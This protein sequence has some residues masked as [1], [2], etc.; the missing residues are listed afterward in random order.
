MSKFPTLKTNF[1]SVVI[2]YKFKLH[3]ELGIQVV[4]KTFYCRM[5]KIK[6]QLVLEL[7]FKCF[8]FELVLHTQ[9]IVVQNLLSC[10][11]LSAVCFFVENKQ[12]ERKKLFNHAFIP[13]SK[14]EAAPF[15][16]S[17]I[18][19]KINFIPPQQ[20]T[21]GGIARMSFRFGIDLGILEY[22]HSDLLIFKQIGPSSSGF[23]KLMLILLFC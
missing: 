22:G 5:F 20:V 23:Y 19:L 11:K 17:K 21:K 10:V 15:Y 12:K 18:S 7:H 14:Q 6:D 16:I 8:M 1:L 4:K 3:D 2:L 13:T 9:S